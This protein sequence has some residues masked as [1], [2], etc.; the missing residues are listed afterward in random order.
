MKLKKCRNCYSKKIEKLF[1]LG[2]LSYSG[3]FPQKKNLNVEKKKYNFG[4]V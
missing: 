4:K 2:N 3:F 1:S